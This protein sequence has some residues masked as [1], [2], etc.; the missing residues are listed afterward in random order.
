MLENSYDATGIKFG[1]VTSKF[2][3]KYSDSL[4][5]KNTVAS[6]AINI[7]K[8]ESISLVD[9]SYVDGLTVDEVLVMGDIQANDSILVC[10]YSSIYWL[11]PNTNDNLKS[12][13]ILKI[14]AIR[15]NKDNHTQL[16][17]RVIEE[18]MLDNYESVDRIGQ[19]VTECFLQRYRY[20]SK[21]EVNKVLSK[22][23]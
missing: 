16:L 15:R 10:A 2:L 22:D 14:Y 19:R 9:Y 1:I 7:F 11:N 23:K 18:V 20:G 6:T 13:N 8:Q 12:F 4:K 3:K 21:E 17:D 5:D